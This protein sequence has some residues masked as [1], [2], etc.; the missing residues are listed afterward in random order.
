M[1]NRVVFPIY[2]FALDR[3]E[4]ALAMA[5]HEYH[6]PREE[7]GRRKR[8]IGEYQRAF[9]AMKNV[10]F[11]SAEGRA[12]AQQWCLEQDVHEVKVSRIAEIILFTVPTGNYN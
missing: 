3:E 8:H 4:E 12:K 2:D 7:D 9:R 11:P 10:I 6:F 1:S 5:G